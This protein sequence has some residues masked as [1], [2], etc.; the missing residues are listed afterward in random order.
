MLLAGL[1]TIDKEQYEAARVDGAGV[2]GR[3]FYIT[4]PNIRPILLVVL[5]FRTMGGVRIFDIVYG[6]TGGGP[7]NATDTLMLGAYNSLFGDLDY[8]MGSAM[9]VLV[10]AIILLLSWLYI[11]FLGRRGGG[12]A[13]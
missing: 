4:L 9:S 5:L 3:F 8:G 10:T 13:L 6:M 1:Q 7:A 11:R 2:F 12:G